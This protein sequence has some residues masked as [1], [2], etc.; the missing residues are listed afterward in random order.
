[1]HFHNVGVR[2]AGQDGNDGSR[3]ELGK[4][5][6]APEHRC[7]ADCPRWIPGILEIAT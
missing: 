6:H 7:G 3:E 4:L 2:Q 5:K 1:M